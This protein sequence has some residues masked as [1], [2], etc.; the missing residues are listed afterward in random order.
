MKGCAK[1]G[2]ALHGAGEGGI[3]RDHCISETRDSLSRG[4]QE[5]GTWALA[6]RRGTGAAGAAPWDHGPCSTGP[7]F[8]ARI[9]SCHNPNIRNLTTFEV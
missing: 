1:G 8:S 6:L 2:E 5:R 7:R 9:L 4:L 3:A